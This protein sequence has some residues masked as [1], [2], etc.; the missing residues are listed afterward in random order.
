[1]DNSMDSMLDVYLFE[2]NSLLES[3]D[4]ILINC[5]KQGTFDSENINEIFRIMH[6]IKGSSAMMQFNSLMTVSHKIEDMFYFVRENG[7]DESNHG[8]LFDLMFKASDFL[9]EEIAHVE[10]NEP[11][12]EDIA[13]ITSEILAML[14]KISGK[15]DSPQAPVAKK[16]EPQPTQKPIEEAKK[17]DPP[18]IEES[19][20]KVRSADE[21]PEHYDT[22]HIDFGVR[23]FFDQE[24]QMENLRAFMLTNSVKDAGV[25]LTF[26]PPDVETNSE[27]M[28]EIIHDGFYM[29]F[30]SEADL[31]KAIKVVEQ[32]IYV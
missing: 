5:E 26:Y 24:C 12:T 25:E 29:M 18:K 20:K 9:K 32:F 28:D 3:L 22:S 31:T 23:V 15:A 19:S 17:E 8:D 6:T 14:N 27:T 4:E 7:L 16:A 13:A 11:L 1:M 10:N 30:K 2:A 21:G